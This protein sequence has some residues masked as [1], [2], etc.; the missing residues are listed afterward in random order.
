MKN[1]ERKLKIG[2]SQR[3]VDEVVKDILECSNEVLVELITIPD[4]SDNASLALGVIALEE[5]EARCDKG[6][7]NHELITKVMI[8]GMV[9]L[10]S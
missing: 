7:V 4:T 9:T 6:K 5:F 2:M 10:L 8:Y 3:L 1:E